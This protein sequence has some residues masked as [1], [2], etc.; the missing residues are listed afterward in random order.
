MR[1]K[2]TWFIEYFLLCY[3]FRLPPEVAGVGVGD[4]VG[5]GFEKRFV[6]GEPG[7]ILNRRVV[8]CVLRDGDEKS[9]L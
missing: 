1:G 4:P 3:I 2:S 7:V 9:I 6:A 5:H 8:V